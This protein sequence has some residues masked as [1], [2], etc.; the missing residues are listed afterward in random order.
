MNRLFITLASLAI[1]L[2]ASAQQVYST[3]FAT[4]NEF[5]KWTVIDENNDGITWKFDAEGSQS[6]V[7]Y[8]YSPSEDAD[9][10]FISPEITPTTTG[11]VMVRYTTYGTS[12]GEKIE[13]YTGTEPTVA[14]MTKLQKKN[15]AVKA[16]RTT[17]YFFYDATAGVPFRVGFHTTSPKDHWK[18]YM[19]AFEV[20][21]VNKVVDMQVANVVSPVSGENLSNAETVKVKVVNN[22]TDAS[23][24]FEVAY[25][26]DGGEAVKEKVDKSLA[27][28]ESMEYTFNKKADLSIP[29]H[30]YTIKAYTIEPND[31]NTDND[32]I[33][34][35]V[36]HNAPMT[37]PCKWGF[38]PGS[39]Q[40]DFKFY[41]LNNDDGDWEV[42]QSNYMNMANTGYGCLAYNYNKD[43]NADDWAM[44]DPIN[45]EAGNYV[46]RYWYSGSDGHTEKLGV[47]WGNGN[48]P[49]DMKNK[50]D[51]IEIKQGKYQEAFNIITFDKPQT[52][53]LGFYAHSD[54]DENWLTVDDVQ[55][56]KAESDAVDLS[57]TD[58]AKPYDFVRTPNDKDLVFTVQNIGIIDTDGNMIVEIDG[59]KK[60][61][62]GIS[63]NAQE[64]KTFTMEGVLGGLSAGKH[65]VKVT[66][67][68]ADDKTT[69]NNS[70]EKEITV[71]GKPSVLYDFE[72]GKIPSD[73]TFYVGDNG[74]VNP[75]A[76]EEFNKEG[77]GI[78]NIEKNY[79]LGEH[80]LAG[81]SWIDNVS[82]PDRWIILP[83]IHVAS[84]DA[85]LAWDAM[86][87]NQ[88][89][90]ED[91]N[92]K[93][94]DGSGNPADYWYTTDMK[95]QGET[96]T[97][98]TRGLSLSKYAGKDI[99][100]AFNLVTKKGEALCLD[101]IGVYS[102][103]TTGITTVGNDSHGIF[104]LDGNNFLAAGAK[105]ITIVDMSGRNV[106]ETNSDAASLSAV[107]PGV[108]VATAKY[109]DGTSKT[110]KFVKK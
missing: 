89:L 90:L 108:Y 97:P 110:F 81:T 57:V 11:K 82:A 14:G 25:Q 12:Y 65:T 15:D 54:K 16:E 86:S 4:E 43:N 69:D 31:I 94:S 5:S 36:R 88:L 93:I 68:S 91:Y 27:A 49:D 100:I 3:D 109:A 48:T 6:H 75:D 102:D 62:D 63:L 83:Q 8:A 20:K 40:D 84:E 13:A 28:G 64:I 35:S 19:C 46:L 78:F 104:S 18:F 24:A 85:V 33:A 23:D 1:T 52:I 103:E 41:N 77:W 53:Y 7:Y 17:D 59:K 22:G 99:Y 9:D 107:Q 98:K 87:F 71:L 58:I 96:V 26:I 34:V 10:W 66:V 73:L 21:Q 37:P 30:K 44:L 70:M 72:S 95:V 92:V 38:E 39:D 29:R 50:V 32:T 80:V 47:Y 60:S 45:V 79:M 42:Y 105:N 2:S 55:F 101:N 74:T 106:A 51:D 67:E 61:E 76:G 56:Y